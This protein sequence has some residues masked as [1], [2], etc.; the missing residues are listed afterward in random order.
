MNRKDL[1][2]KLIDWWVE[3]I[4]QPLNQNNGDNS[5]H[6]FNS[7]ILLNTLSLVHQKKINEDNI[8][9]FKEKLYN[10]LINRSQEDLFL[11]VDY[12]PCDDLR[13]A[14]D[15]SDINYSVFP[16]KTITILKENSVMVKKG[17]NQEFKKI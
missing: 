9:L 1:I 11:D 3:V 2:K 15:Y 14:A 4:Q 8:V 5:N 12:V 6:P 10:I 16:C 17:Y 7:T 13:E